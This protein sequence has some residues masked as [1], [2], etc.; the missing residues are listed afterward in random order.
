MRVRRVRGSKRQKPFSRS[1]GVGFLPLSRP[2][3]LSLRLPFTRG[4][5]TLSGAGWAREEEQK[6]ES[7]GAKDGNK[8]KRNQ[9]A[10]SSNSTAETKNSLAARGRKPSPEN[11]ALSFS[12]S[13]FRSRDPLLRGLGK[14]GTARTGKAWKQEKKPSFFVFVVESRL[15][16]SSLQRPKRK[17]SR[18]AGALPAKPA[19]SLRGN[20]RGGGLTG[21]R[22]GAEREDEDG[23]DLHGCWRWWWVVVLSSGGD[24]G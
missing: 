17:P 7:S 18:R 19:L 11:P 24:F 15:D 4:S 6:G 20:T 10:F 23:E 13:P 21:C 8:E 22:D 5:G 14:R 9:L 12:S 2:L 3:S 16:S 1:G